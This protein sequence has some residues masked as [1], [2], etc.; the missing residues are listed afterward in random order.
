MSNAPCSNVTC[1]NGGECIV[2][3]KGPQCTCPKPY[4]GD[5]CELSKFEIEGEG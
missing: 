2:D 5:R 3:E 4:Y 1:L